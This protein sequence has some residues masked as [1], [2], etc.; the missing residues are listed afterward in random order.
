MESQV[1]EQFDNS[2]NR[3]GVYKLH[4]AG[5]NV[6][7]LGYFSALVADNIMVVDSS[8]NFMLIK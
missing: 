6:L 1:K 5:G 2:N 4:F 8:V 3:P 7:I